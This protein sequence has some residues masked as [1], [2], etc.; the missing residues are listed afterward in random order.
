MPLHS[1]LSPGMTTPE[2]DI[3]LMLEIFQC[4]VVLYSASQWFASCMVNDILVICW[5]V[6]F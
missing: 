6:Y 1:E 2:G 5:H 3:H 4:F